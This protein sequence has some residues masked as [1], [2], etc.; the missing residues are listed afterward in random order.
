MADAATLYDVQNDVAVITLNNPP[1]NGLGLEI[2][3]GLKTHIDQAL[4]DSAIKAVVIT[5]NGSM[6]CGG[7]D[8][9][10]FNT[11]KASMEPKTAASLEAIA[12]GS[13]PVIAA[14]HGNALG[15]GL[16]LALGCHYRISTA[17]ANLG[18]PEVKLG[19]LPG[20]GGTQRL[21]RLIGAEKAL[22]MIV[23]GKP[24]NGAKAMKLGLVDKVVDRDLVKAAVAFAQHKAGESSHPVIAQMSVQGASEE[25]FASA[26]TQAAR[27][28]RGFP[29]P[30]AC[31]ACVEAATRL[32]FDEGL[33]FERAEFTKLVEGPES[34][35]QRYLFFAE[36]QA[37]KIPDIPTDTKA[38]ALD[39]VG[40][41]G[42]GTMGA[43]IAMS[44]ASAGVPVTIFE[45]KSEALDRGME[46]IK[47]NY[48]ATVSKGRLSQ[49]AMD[50][51]LSQITPT[52]N[53]DD[54]AN[55]LKKWM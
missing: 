44:F 29:A 46:R 37:R 8:I 52:L 11:P 19:L 21:P 31:I 45:A 17:D 1:V 15:G 13:K 25:A 18:L 4:A 12:A 50:A 14:I 55:A 24:V 54:L 9:R 49:T 5:G 23:S 43:G 27:R 26:R 7:A 51:A 20:G 3:Q 32:P 30:L 34:K 38:R 36:R 35:A 16:E 40:I 48:A 2:R 6:F 47:G 42:A 10:Q 53:F 39:Q 28:Q 41:M 33:A 22:D